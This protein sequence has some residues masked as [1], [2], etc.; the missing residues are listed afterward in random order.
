MLFLLGHFQK[1]LDSSKDWLGMAVESID[2]QIVPTFA[3]PKMITSALR[4]SWKTNEKMEIMF[5]ND[6]QRDRLKGL[7][8]ENK[9]GIE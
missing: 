7:V 3:T 2:G 1:M 6:T 9:K 4:R 8:D 5:C